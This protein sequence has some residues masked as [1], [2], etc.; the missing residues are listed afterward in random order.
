V[1][2]QVRC[3]VRGAGGAG[4]AVLHDD[5]DR[6][7]LLLEEVSYARDHESVGGCKGGQSSGLRTDIADL[8]GP[9][10]SCSRS[11]KTRQCRRAECNATRLNDLPPVRHD[12]RV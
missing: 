6:P 5:V 10:R 8:D 12:R 4:L 2:N 1:E 3:H 9:G 11:G 7:I